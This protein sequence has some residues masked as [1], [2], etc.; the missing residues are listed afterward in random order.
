MWCAASAFV[1]R[2]L[3]PAAEID[4]RADDDRGRFPRTQFL[5]RLSRQHYHRAV[6][7]VQVG[8]DDRAATAHRRAESAREMSRI[9]KQERDEVRRIVLDVVQRR[10]GKEVVGGGRILLLTVDEKRYAAL[11]KPVDGSSYE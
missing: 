4:H 10:A 2:Q 6:A 3:D 1:H 7:R 5:G 9:A 8:H 11:H